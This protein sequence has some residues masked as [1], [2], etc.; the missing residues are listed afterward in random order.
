M[1]VKIIV[2][3][4]CCEN[5]AFFDGEIGGSIQFCKAKE[6]ETIEEA[7]CENFQKKEK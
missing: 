4:V 5:C 7:Y 6:V 1:E 3:D 2:T